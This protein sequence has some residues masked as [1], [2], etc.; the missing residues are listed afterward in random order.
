[1]TAGLFATAFTVRAQSDPDLFFQEYT[2]AARLLHDGKPQDAMI[3]MDLLQQKLTVSPWREIALLK[4]A[5]LNE[6]RNWPLAKEAYAT[7]RKRL[8]ETPYFQGKVDRE[9]LFR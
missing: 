1:M 8:D 9:Q 7:L 2:R 6:S 3:A 4:Y 5:E